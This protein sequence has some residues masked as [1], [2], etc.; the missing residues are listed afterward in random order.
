MEN[1]PGVALTFTQ[2][3]DM[4]VSEMLTGVRGDLAIKLYG[5]DL[6]TLN[7][8]ASEIEAVVKT[9][10]GAE[11]TITIRN[12]GV[13]YLRIQVDRL[14]AGRFGL[15]VEDVQ[16]ALRSLLEGRWPAP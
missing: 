9:V 4:R 15:N 11:D 16:N 13:Q 12:E 3:I 6:P 10:P 5:P 7:R 14:A 1:F 2:P 8:L